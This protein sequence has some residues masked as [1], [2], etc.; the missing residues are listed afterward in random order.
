[1]SL[2]TL[3]GTGIRDYFPTILD[4][5]FVEHGKP[6]PEIYQKAAAALHRDPSTCVVIE[7][8]LSG[9]EAALKAGCR[10]VGIT[11]THSPEELI[12]TDYVIKSFY[13]GL[14]PY[15]LFVRVGGPA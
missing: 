2:F 15:D 3:N 6:N 4:E 5:S 8:S 14:D 12:H 7:D 1:M 9:I 10:V 11:M 13:V